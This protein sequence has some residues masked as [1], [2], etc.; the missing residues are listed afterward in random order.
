MKVPTNTV[1]AAA[2]P[3]PRLLGF[4]EQAVLKPDALVIGAWAMDP[5]DGAAPARFVVEWGRQNFA[6]EPNLVR[7]DVTGPRSLPP[8][9]VGVRATI[10]LRF[11]PHDSLDGARIVAHW[12]DGRALELTALRSLIEDG[13]LKYLRFETPQQFHDF[14]QNPAFRSASP[15]LQAYG[16]ARAMRLAGENTNMWLSG[17]VVGIYRHLDQGFFRRDAAEEAIALWKQMQVKERRSATGLTLR[18]ATSMHLA[19]G[20]AHLAWGQ[21]AEAR[22]EFLAMSDYTERMNTWPQCLTNLGIGRFIAAFLTIRLGEAERAR[23]ML[24]GVENMFPV[25]VGPLKIWNFHMFEELR[26]ALKVWQYNFVLQKHLAGEKAA[27]ILP[28]TFSFRLANVSA[29]LQGLVDQG[30]VP[31]WKIPVD[32]LPSVVSHKRPEGEI[33]LVHQA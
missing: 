25:G 9:M 32:A 15:A 7:I 3:Q 13:L 2:S 22:D 33:N 31:D 10:P 8:D 30:L 4:W 23:D 27:H 21:I 29:V 20:Y 1:P 19:A 5:A 18:W 16:A 11:D 17:A 14:F 12:R 26:G 24:V 6:V 28:P